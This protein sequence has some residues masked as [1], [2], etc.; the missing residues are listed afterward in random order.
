MGAYEAQQGGQ[1]SWNEE[2]QGKS[3]KRGQAGDRNMYA[4]DY[5]DF[6]Q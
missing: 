5:K 1:W 2:S 6:T 3:S 4:I